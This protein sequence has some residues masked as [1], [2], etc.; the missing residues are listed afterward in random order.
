M[1]HFVALGPILQ[2]CLL[3]SWGKQIIYAPQILEFILLSDVHECPRQG[4]AHCSRQEEER[5]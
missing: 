3:H 4:L 5:S 2:S 1:T